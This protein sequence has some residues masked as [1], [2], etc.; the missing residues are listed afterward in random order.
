MKTIQIKNNITSEMV[1]KHL[2]R[3][4]EEEEKQRTARTNYSPM[5][6]GGGY[7]SIY[8][9]EWSNLNATPKKFTTYREFFKFLEDCSIEI[10]ESQRNLAYNMY[11]IYAVCKK[12][13]P[14]LMI[15]S[16]YCGLRLLLMP[17]SHTPTPNVP[18]LS[19]S[20]EDA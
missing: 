3:I 2:K 4:K 20:S 6:S 7:V 8:F 12:N 10:T 18:M 19:R 16:T 14:K 15:S 17:E 11:S 13:E 9:Y 1:E 5:Y